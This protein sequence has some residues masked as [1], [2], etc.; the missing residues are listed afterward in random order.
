[1]WVSPVRPVAGA[2]RIARV[3]EI[4][5]PLPVQHIDGAPEVVLGAAII[6]GLPTPVVDASRMLGAPGSASSGIFVILGVDGRRVALAVTSV[7]GVRVLG[8]E[9]FTALP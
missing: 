5:R 6:R 4:M 1:S 3:I 2:L 8:P 7:Q 9:S